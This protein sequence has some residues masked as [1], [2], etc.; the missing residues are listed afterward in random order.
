[1]GRRSSV[2]VPVLVLLASPSFRSV[3]QQPLDIRPDLASACGN[4]PNP[5]YAPA[6]QPPIRDYMSFRWWFV[7]QPGATTVGRIE[8]PND[9]VAWPDNGMDNMAYT[10]QGMQTFRQL[11]SGGDRVG[12]YFDPNTNVVGV[13]EQCG[14]ASIYVVVR[15]KDKP[16]GLSTVDYVP[17]ATEKGV[18]LGMTADQ[19]KAL[20]GASDSYHTQHIDDFLLYQWKKRS[21]CKRCAP[22][23]YAMKFDFENGQ[24]IAMSYQVWLHPEIHWHSIDD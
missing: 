10:T 4:F 24:L 14:T 5:D 22:D 2:F 11:A 1:M 20:V 9:A 21:D 7:H 18:K 17:Q 6:F 8:I 19:V 13:L 23:R 16:A 3:A 12:A 15:A